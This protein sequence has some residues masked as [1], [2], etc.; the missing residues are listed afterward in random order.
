MD[1]ALTAIVRLNI[2]SK[3]KIVLGFQNIFA[4]GV[5][6]C[7]GFNTTRRY[8]QMKSLR[9]FFQLTTKIIS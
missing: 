6:A 8:L 2:P 1:N 7:F 3:N 5:V 4:M 9:R